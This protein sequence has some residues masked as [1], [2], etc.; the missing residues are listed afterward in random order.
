MWKSYYEGMKLLGI[1]HGG[2]ITNPTTPSIPAFPFNQVMVDHVK[3]ETSVHLELRIHASGLPR[4]GI[5]TL[6][7]CWTQ[8]DLLEGPVI[9]TVKRKLWGSTEIVPNSSHP[10]WTK[11]LPLQYQYGSEAYFYVTI[12]SKTDKQGVVIGGALF[13]VSDVLG[14]STKTKRLPNGGCVSCT[15][16]PIRSQGDS[17]FKCRFQALSLK[18]NSILWGL[19]TY[20]EVAKKENNSTGTAWITIYRSPPVFG[21]TSPM[22]D[23][24]QFLGIDW[25]ASLRLSIWYY[26]ENKLLGT[27][28]T[29]W[30]YLFD[31]CTC[32]EGAKDESSKDLILG[33]PGSNRAEVG[34]LRVLEVEALRGDE[35]SEAFT[36]QRHTNDESEGGT[37]KILSASWQSRRGH[38]KS[39]ESHSG[40]PQKSFQDYING[41]VELDMIVAIDFTS[42]NG[43]PRHPESLHYQT[44]NSLNDYQEVISTVGN[45]IA[46]YSISKQFPVLGFGAKFGGIVRHIFQCGPTSDVHGID[47]ILQAYQSVFQTDIIMSGPTVLDQVIQAAAMRAKKLCQAQADSQYCILLILTDGIVTDLSGTK[48]KLEVYSHLPLSVIIIGV[49]Q[50]DFAVMNSLESSGAGVRRTVTVVKLRQ[51]QH[52]PSSIV[53]AALASLPEQIVEYF[54]RDQER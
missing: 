39:H 52:D 29:T 47:G 49:G 34:K 6:P 46:S 19:D 21:S 17:I 11:T 32:R 18:A 8:V 43:D 36:R 31:A 45:A 40:S 41:G 12:Y 54:Q 16:K 10:Q 44:P 7:S 22:F 24:T 37:S 42:S 9:A 5:R 13:E 53:K 51:H 50:A 3:E 14:T 38:T 15:L 28:E 27:C 26:K 25:N 2:T 30:K 4:S 23:P 35:D 33:G 20:L 1:L 48:R